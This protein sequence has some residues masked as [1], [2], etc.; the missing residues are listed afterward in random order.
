VAAQ[1]YVTTAGTLTFGVNET[2]RT[3]TI[4]ILADSLQEGPESFTVTLSTPTGGA[5]LG[6]PVAATVTIVDTTHATAPPHPGDD[7]ADDE[8]VER[9]RETDEERRQRA[10]TNQ[11]NRDDDAVEGD[12][13]ETHCEAPWP[14]AVIAN[15]DGAVEVKLLKDAQKACSSIQVGDYLE[16][17]GEKQHEGLFYADSVEIKRRR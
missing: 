12:V 10:R 13:I 8:R 16:A 7:S 15:R 11:G 4:P 2:S 9:E 17:D 1:D 14:Y 3:I 5:T 6:V